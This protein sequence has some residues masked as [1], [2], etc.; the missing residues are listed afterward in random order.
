MEG[1]D[2]SST[3]S[4]ESMEEENETEQREIISFG[5]SNEER[6][7]V[8]IVSGQL[9]ARS[10]SIKF[11]TGPSM[12]Q[13]IGQLYMLTNHMQFVFESTKSLDMHITK[14]QADQCAQSYLR[15]NC[16]HYDDTIVPNYVPRS[17]KTVESHIKISTAL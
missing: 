4:M 11:I 17:R 5:D 14:E 3:S 13:I 2:V 6:T 1:T 12:L 7:A 9:D 8:N 16:I 15:D 10:K